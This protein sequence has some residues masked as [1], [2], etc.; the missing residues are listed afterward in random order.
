M[1]PVGLGYLL[2]VPRL[3][4]RSLRLTDGGMPEGIILKNS[5]WPLVNT[6]RGYASEP[7]LGAGKR[8]GV[9]CVLSAE[10]E[11]TPTDA[12]VVE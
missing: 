2:I 7:S 11:V 8:F 12:K 9:S 3:A 10:R 1:G 4:A 6:K 5:K